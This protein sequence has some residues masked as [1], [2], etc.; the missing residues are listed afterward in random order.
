M[1]TSRFLFTSKSPGRDFIMGLNRRRFFTLLLPATAAIAAGSTA[2]A[3]GDP[4]PP[5]ETQVGCLVDTTLCVGCRQCEEACNRRNEL[6]RPETPFRDRSVFRTDRRPGVNNFTVVNEFPGAPSR[7]QPDKQSTYAKT[8]CMHCLDPAC[9]S[10]CIVGA[11]TKAKDGAVVYNP[12]ICIGCRYC[13]IACPFQIPSYEYDEILAP[14]VRK[15]EFCADQAEGTGADP[16]CAAACPVEAIVFGKRSELLVLAR[17][18][19][20][21]RP[22]RYIDHIYGEHEIGGTSW[23]YLYGREM[24]EISLLPLPTYAPPRMTEAIQHT[25]FKYGA[26]PFLVYGTLGGIMWHNLRKQ[27]VAADP[28]GGAS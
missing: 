15:C 6:P 7:D 22:V 12:S 10:A 18:R 23:L 19:I 2:A 24:E 9:V 8:Q 14:K 20:D 4:P 17:S 25:I 27:Q 16:A 1:K 5:D 21:R 26:I 28:D 3:T 11:L 13:L